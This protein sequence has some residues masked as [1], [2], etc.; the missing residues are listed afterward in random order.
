MSRELAKAARDTADKIE[1][2]GWYGQGVRWSV[3]DSSHCYC[4]I[5]GVDLDIMPVFL[6]AFASYVG[7]Q[8]DSKALYD[9]RDYVIAWNDFQDGPE[10]VIR[11]LREFAA[12]QD[13]ENNL[14]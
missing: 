9:S 14:V 7:Y 11:T 10:V 13:K 3:G 8:P 6:D 12:A 1:R 4:V 2:F 5:T